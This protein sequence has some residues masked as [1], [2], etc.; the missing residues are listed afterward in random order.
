MKGELPEAKHLAMGLNTA[1]M[2]K[3]AIDTSESNRLCFCIDP[4]KSF[5]LKPLASIFIED[6]SG[7]K[8]ALYIFRNESPVDE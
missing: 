1:R 6:L 7:D 4:C 5:V 3:T 8:D 2:E